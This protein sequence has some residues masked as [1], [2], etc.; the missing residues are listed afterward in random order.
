MPKQTYKIEGFHGGLNSNA[1]PRDIDDIEASELQNMKISKLGRLK[2]I[3]GFD[4][5]SFESP[6]GGS[7][8]LT[9]KNRGLYAM[10]A[11]RKVSDN[12]ES[13]ETLLFLYDTVSD[14]FDVQDSGGFTLDEISINTTNPVYYN[15]D[16]ILRI[17]DGSFTN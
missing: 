3:G 12:A 8:C 17:G 7:G 10:D 5:L 6:E 13:N 16:G 14:A 11:D 1:D 4:T 2:T 9:L 15:A